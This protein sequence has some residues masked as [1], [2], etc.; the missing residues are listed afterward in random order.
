M[1]TEK[2]VKQLFEKYVLNTY[3]RIGPVFVKGKGD[4]LWDTE[5]NRYLD[6][7][8]GWGVS[9]LG[10]SH[11]AIAKTIAQQAKQLIHLPNNLFQVPQALLAQEIV[12]HSFDAKVFFANSGAE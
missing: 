9:I 4:W 8:P 5:G 12:G 2:N 7:F 1:K 10:H 3:R 6:L 11:Q